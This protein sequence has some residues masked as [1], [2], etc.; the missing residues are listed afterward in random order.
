[1]IDELTFSALPLD[2]QQ[3]YI[4]TGGKNTITT[5]YRLHGN[6]IDVFHGETF[7]CWQRETFEHEWDYK[8]GIKHC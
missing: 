4:D 3:Y 5:Y 1:M 6:R 8:I 7:D 2:I